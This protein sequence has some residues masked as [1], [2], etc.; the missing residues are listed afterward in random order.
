MIDSL[1]LA[2]RPAAACRRRRNRRKNKDGRPAALALMTVNRRS[3]EQSFDLFILAVL[4]EALLET[5]ARDGGFHQLRIDG[6]QRIR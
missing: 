2:K 1:H 5:R 6:A 3:G 4:E